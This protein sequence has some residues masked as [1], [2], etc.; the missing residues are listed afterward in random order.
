MT[1]EWPWIHN[2]QK[3]AVYIKYLP[4]IEVQI[5]VR[6]PRRPAVFNVQG[7]WKSQMHRMTSDWSWTHDNQKYPVNSINTYHRGTN[8][9]PVCSTTSPFPDRKFRKCTEWPQ[10]D[11]EWNLNSQTYFINTNPEAQTWVC[12]FL[13]TASSFWD[14][15]LLKIGNAPDDLSLTLNT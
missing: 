13:F 2:S 8:F 7:C 14:T 3:Y 4:P 6:F 5:F 11:F 1:S 15:R 12:T 9:G 10:I